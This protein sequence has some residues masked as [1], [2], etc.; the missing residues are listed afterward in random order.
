MYPYLIGVSKNT[1]YFIVESERNPL[2]SYLIRIVYDEKKRVINYSCSCK[3]FAI[4]GKCK[5][6]S[7]ARNKVKFIN[8][9]RV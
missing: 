4:R 7:I 8:E 2:E 9:K 1:Y 3:G 5:H 6:I